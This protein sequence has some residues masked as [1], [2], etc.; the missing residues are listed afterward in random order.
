MVR[1]RPARRDAGEGEGRR[2]DAA[3]EWA[4]A[5]TAPGFLGYLR[6]ERGLRAATIR[7][8][9]HDLRLLEAFTAPRGASREA[10]L[11]WLASL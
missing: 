1:A 2:A 8:C 5:E 7:A 11:A 6:D 10:M 9:A 4:F 3:L